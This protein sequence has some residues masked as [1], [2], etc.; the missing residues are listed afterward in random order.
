MRLPYMSS[1]MPGISASRGTAGSTGPSGL[2]PASGPVVRQ[3]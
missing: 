3:R 1:L 2:V